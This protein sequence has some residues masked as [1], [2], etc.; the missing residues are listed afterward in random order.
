VALV[1]TEVSEERISSSIMVERISEV[2]TMLAVTIHPNKGGN[3]MPRKLRFYKSHMASYPRRRLLLVRFEDFTAV[4]MKN[5][6]FWDV[7]PG[8]SCKNRR[9]GGT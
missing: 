1:R 9:F 5:G 4:T 6:V 3:T 2:G 7:T 8:G